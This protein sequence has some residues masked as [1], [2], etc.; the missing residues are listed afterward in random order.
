[1]PSIGA[2]L[3]MLELHLSKRGRLKRARMRDFAYLRKVVPNRHKMRRGRRQSCKAWSPRKRVRSSPTAA[4]PYGTSKPYARA[5]VG[6]DDVHLHDLSHTFASRL[7]QQG[8]SL[9]EVM[10]LTG[11]ESVSMVQR[12]A[13]LAPDFQETA[14]AALEAFGINRAQPEEGPAANVG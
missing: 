1:M 11:H 12:Y 2:I 6:L 7:V 9:Y 13:H 10:H 4:R 5:K 8:V 14:I 3:R